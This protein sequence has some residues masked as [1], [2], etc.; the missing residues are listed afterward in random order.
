MRSERW[1]TH[2]KKSEQQHGGGLI[3]RDEAKLAGATIYNSLGAE[4]IN[5]QITL[6]ICTMKGQV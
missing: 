4:L 5:Q 6:Q 2:S 1:S 3:A